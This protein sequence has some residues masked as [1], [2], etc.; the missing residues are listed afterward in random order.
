MLNQLLQLNKLLNEN[1]RLGIN[2]SLDKL[3]QNNTLPKP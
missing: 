1:L 2:C 3:I